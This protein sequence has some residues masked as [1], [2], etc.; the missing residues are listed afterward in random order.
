[1]RKNS[2]K[3][4]AMILSLC[5]AGSAL[6]QPLNIYASDVEEMTAEEA[7]S[8][9][10]EEVS[11]EIS[12][13]CAEEEKTE[14]Q[15][16]MEEQEAVPSE[17][18]TAEDSTE[19]L[20]EEMPAEAETAVPVQEEEQTPADLQPVEAL[21]ATSADNE[22]EENNSKKHV[23]IDTE[24]ETPDV[25]IFADEKVLM[26]QTNEELRV[27]LSG[28]SPVNKD[29]T[30]EAI[31]EYY[32]APLK[33]ASG[34]YSYIEFENINFIDSEKWSTDMYVEY[35]SQLCWAAA[36]SNAIWES[37]W[38]NE[39]INPLTNRKFASSDEIFTY[40]ATY[41]EDKEGNEFYGIQWFM[42]AIYLPNSMEDWSHLTQEDEKYARVNGYGTGE[43]QPGL[44]E[45]YC[46][47][48]LLDYVLLSNDN[49]VNIQKL[50]SLLQNSSVGM[51]V[52]FIDEFGEYSG[53]HAITVMGVIVDETKEGIDQYVA[54]LIADSDNNP[55]DRDIFPLNIE[56]ATEVKSQQPNIYTMYYLDQFT[57]DRGNQ[58]W[59]LKDYQNGFSTILNECIALK[60]LPSVD[61][62]EITE[63]EGTKDVFTSPDLSLNEIRM[64]NEQLEPVLYYKEGEGVTFYWSITNQA[65]VDIN[66]ET[67]ACD[68]LTHKIEIYK[69]GKLCK[70]INTSMDLRQKGNQLAG[71]HSG[72]YIDNLSDYYKFEPGVYTV[73]FYINVPGEDGS[74][75]SE[76]YYLNN[77]VQEVTFTVIKGE[78]PVNPPQEQTVEKGDRETDRVMIKAVFVNKQDQE[79]VRFGI[80]DKTVDGTFYLDV[81]VESSLFKNVYC[82]GEKIDPTYY[83]VK[84]IADDNFRIIIDNAFMNTL[85]KGEHQFDVELACLPV[86]YPVKVQ[87]VE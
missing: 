63:T 25:Y 57:D 54:L 48:S 31:R 14:V 70:I 36:A 69:D 35:D 51:T 12:E 62:K 1:M 43:V 11:E 74:R 81:N 28:L 49:Q 83:E 7:I 47:D 37:G 64:L 60:Q 23:S 22:S 82:D 3:L 87:V 9:A 15:G 50:P 59:R 65:R 29:K 27:I 46:V 66:P 10:E 8:Q 55:A 5:M 79:D 19:A 84:D 32:K 42:D 77:K 38:A 4:T 40:F 68:T 13:E 73:K 58:F 78:D 61:V 45:E 33:D 67:A 75:V 21:P 56:Q 41:F 26:K 20:P 72:A 76:A 16:E 53:G 18:E 24:E 34:I 17:V 86:P 2:G 6:L 80:Y 52:R 39:V 30:I 85:E 44:L 71:N